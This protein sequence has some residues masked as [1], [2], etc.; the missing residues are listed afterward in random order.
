M[1]LLIFPA[2]KEV[3]VFARY[4]DMIEGFDDIVFATSKGAGEEPVDFADLDG[5]PVTGI[6]VSADFDEALRNVDAVFFSE[7]AKSL[8]SGFVLKKFEA[9]ISSGKKVYTEYVPDGIQSDAVTVLNGDGFPADF[10]TDGGRDNV[11][12]I[13]V[14]VVFI[15]GSGPNT[16]KFLTQVALRKFFQ[17]EGYAISQVGTKRCS[18]FFGFP[19]IPSWV[20]QSGLNEREKIVALNRFF[21]SRYVQDK[22]EVMLI[23]IPGGFM[24]MNPMKYEEMGTLAYLISQAVTPDAAVFCSYAMNFTAEYMEWQKNVCRYKLNVP[25][26]HMVISNTSMEVSLESRKCEYFTTPFSAFNNLVLPQNE[27]IEFFNSLDK[28]S[29]DSLGRSLLTLLENN[30]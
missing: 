10:S 8:S 3:N 29:M 14:P 28:E 9:A 26:R 5:G 12:E 27:G 17:N 23:G 6:Y 7:T 13:P 19:S 4:S 20:Y 2:A 25:I 21:Y 22:P 15:F 30:L 18:N 24:P 1:R 11:Y 16:H